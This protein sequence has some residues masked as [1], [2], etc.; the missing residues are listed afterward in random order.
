MYWDILM[1]YWKNP[2]NEWIL[3]EYTIKYKDT[4][5]VCSEEVEVYILI[6][7]YKNTIKEFSFDG[8]MSIIWTAATSAIWEH[9]IG[10]SINEVL[11][12]NYETIVELLWE[13]I[14][15]RR[16]WASVLGLLNIKNALDIYI[17]KDSKWKYSI[18]DMY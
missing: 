17:N 7:E 8:D 12:Y 18:E 15:E 6:D 9:I 16:R 11:S 2:S 4:Q 14:P 1:Q 10:K 5:H 3:D 13:E